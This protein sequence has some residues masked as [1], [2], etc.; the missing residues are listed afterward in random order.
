MRFRGSLI[1]ALA[2]SVSAA[3]V[4][5][6][7]ATTNFTS[8]WDEHSH[9]SYVQYVYNFQLPASGYPMNTWGREAFACHPHHLYGSM[10][11]AACGENGPGTSYPTGGTNTAEGWP[12]LSYIVIANLARPFF[13]VVDD[14]LYASRGAVVVLWTL[15]M[16]ALA[17]LA[18]QRGM[19]KVQTV[20][21][22]LAVSALPGLGY[23]SSFVSPYSA[24]P[25]LTAYAIWSFGWLV[26]LA[27]DLKVERT[28]R[29][30]AKSLAV[31]LFPTVSVLTIPHS[32]SVVIAISVG[33]SIFALQSLWR[34]KTKYRA[35]FTLITAVLSAFLSAT[36]YF[37]YRV[38]NR[39]NGS[40][41]V[42]YPPDTL[43]DTPPPAIEHDPDWIGQA[44][45]RAWNFFPNAI[46]SALPV[47]RALAFFSAL[48]TALVV[49]VVVGSA[50]GLL[51]SMDRGSLAIAV[52]TASPIGALI[53]YYTLSFE[54]PPRYGL[55][56]AFLGF[57]LLLTQPLA[58]RATTVLLIL[59]LALTSSALVADPI[60]IEQPCWEVGPDGYLQQCPE[61]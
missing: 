32:I 4:P 6:C 30:S 29:F 53:F 60:Y 39:F 33:I 19:S 45:A 38:Y 5:A 51:R 24:V 59:G 41:V 13:L 61:A 26:T 40:R 31:L 55:P 1:F 3:L 47:P 18:V 15:G 43:P 11:L 46:G 34:K 7:R 52:L 17:A 58:K 27:E 28:W 8:A 49:T 44:V 35:A 48:L 57:A 37:A 56:L 42:P 10:A 25:I 22:T 16:L 21:W 12:P 50:L 2:V 20:S 54:P 14:P 36:A 23:F 9:L